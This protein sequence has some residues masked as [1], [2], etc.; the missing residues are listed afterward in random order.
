[1]ELQIYGA[2]GA[3]GRFTATP[4]PDAALAQDGTILPLTIT[5]AMVGLIWRMPPSLDLHGYAG[6]EKTKAAFMDVGTVPFGYRNPLY[7]NAGCNTENSPGARCNG[8]TREVRQNHR[9][10]LRYDQPGCLRPRR[11]AYSIFTISGS[12]SKASA[13]RQGQTSASS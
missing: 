6:L 2:C 1:L 5:S 3:L 4:F 11:P 9:R 12:P 10:D 7:N 8:N 13:A